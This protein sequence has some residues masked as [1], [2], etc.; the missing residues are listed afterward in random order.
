MTYAT[1]TVSIQ[2]SAPVELYEF[3]TPVATYRY[4]SFDTDFTYAANVYTSLAGLVRSSIEVNAA[5]EAQELQVSMPVST[6]FIQQNMFSLPRTITCR[7]RILQRVSAEAVIAWQGLITNFSISGRT[8][9]VHVPSLMDD[10][11]ETEIPT[12]RFQRRCNHFLYDTMCKVLAT[13][14]DLATTVG[15]IAGSV[16]TVAGIGGNPDNWFQNG[17]VVRTTDGERRLIAKQVGT[18]LTINYPFR[19]LLPGDALTLFAGCDHLITTCDSK[20]DNHENFGGHP[21]IEH[22]FVKLMRLIMGKGT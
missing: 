15:V 9:Q 11:L 8:A 22:R 18:T 12:V 20:F 13:D 3:V 6:P 1:D 19:A 10:A 2:G 5:T 16:I 21:H 4:T 7:V 14:Y 17:E